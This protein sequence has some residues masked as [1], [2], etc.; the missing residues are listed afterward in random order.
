MNRQPPEPFVLTPDFSITAEWR[1]SFTRSLI[2]FVAPLSGEFVVRSEH[3]RPADPAEC[4]TS[5][6]CVSARFLQLEL[7]V[8]SVDAGQAVLSTYLGWSGKTGLVAVHS[9][10][11]PTEPEEAAEDWLG[12]VGG[13]WLDFLD[14]GVRS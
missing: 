1:G 8:T 14:A 5:I 13:D 7:Y 12:A 4:I 3:D 9:Q 10:E 11:L 6:G 2:A